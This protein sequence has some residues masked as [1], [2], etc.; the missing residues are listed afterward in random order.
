MN[1]TATAPGRPRP[2]AGTRAACR[3]VDSW[4]RPGDRERLPHVPRLRRPGDT[5]DPVRRVRLV[6]VLRQPDPLGAV[7][8]RQLVD[9]VVDVAERDAAAAGRGGCRRLGR[10][11][12]V[13]MV[14]VGV[15]VAGTR[16]LHRA[17]ERQ[18]RD[19]RLLPARVVVAARRRD[20][21]RNLLL[22]AASTCARRRRR[23]CRSVRSRSHSGSPSASR[24][25]ATVGSG[26]SGGWARS[27]PSSSGRAG[28]ASRRHGRRC[29]CSGS[30]PRTRTHAAAP[31]CVG[32]R[33]GAPPPF[34]QAGVPKIVNTSST[35]YRSAC[36]A[37][38]SYRCQS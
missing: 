5:E 14:G 4:I 24:P 13:R 11:A 18:R 8:A 25:A 34:A 12:V 16:L 31:R 33:V 10:C 19:G 27:T 7:E 6:A 38:R 37:T 22:R 17:Q 29:R 28:A 9:E 21:A 35:P 20:A 1:P 26:R 3:S 15:E 32:A 23:R 2:G 30:R 36:R